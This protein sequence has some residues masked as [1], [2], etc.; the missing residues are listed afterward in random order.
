[1]RRTRPRRWMAALLLIGGLLIPLLAGGS[2]SA[3]RE[4]VCVTPQGRVGT[5]VPN[6]HVCTY[7]QVP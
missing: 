5:V 6:G 7:V 4:R 2:A 3:I 1:M